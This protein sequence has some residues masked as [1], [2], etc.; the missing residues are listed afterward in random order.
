MQELERRVR[1]IEIDG[2]LWGACKLSNDTYKHEFYT[3]YYSSSRSIG[4]Y[5]QE[6]TNH[7]CRGR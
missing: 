4:L 1:S 6:T 2:L 5:N 3:I 7:M